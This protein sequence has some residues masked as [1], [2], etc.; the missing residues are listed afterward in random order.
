MNLS[1]S[2]RCSTTVV[3][4]HRA[5]TKAEACKRDAHYQQAREALCRRD[6]TTAAAEAVASTM[7]HSHHPDAH[8]LAGVA[9]LQLGLI[10]EAEEALLEAVDQRP[11]FPEA[12][13]KLAYIYR[14][15]RMDFFKLGEHLLMAAKAERTMPER[16]EPVFAA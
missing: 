9:L 12:H 13:L 6:Y 7:L 4:N 15:Y 8:F 3:T 10:D 16:A 14:K 11:A 2:F 5:E 1:D